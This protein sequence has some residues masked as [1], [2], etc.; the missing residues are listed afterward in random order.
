MHVSRN[1]MRRSQI[2][3]FL[4]TVLF[5]SVV[6]P[7]IAPANENHEQARRLKESGQILPLE[8][9]IKAAQAEHPGRVIEVDLENKKGRHVYEVELLDQ[10]G[11]VWELYFDAVSGE[12][13]KRKQDD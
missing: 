12:L 5:M 13:I 11:K 6:L 7:A 3:G 2:T 10:Q 9:I 4:S 8:Q 1:E